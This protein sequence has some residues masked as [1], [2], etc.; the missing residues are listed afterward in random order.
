MIC[1]REL[2][3]VALSVVR[4]LWTRAARDRSSLNHKLFFFFFFFFFSFF[5]YL[6]FLFVF[7]NY[8]LYS[9]TLLIYTSQNYGIQLIK[10]TGFHYG[11]NTELSCSTNVP[12]DLLRFETYFK[13]LKCISNPFIMFSLFQRKLYMYHQGF[14]SSSLQLLFSFFI[15]L[16]KYRR[17]IYTM[18]FRLIEINKIK[19]RV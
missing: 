11:F 2:W 4:L 13:I 9:F 16:R 5:F 10:L 8:F 7:R 3:E 14:S 17:T 1:N 18:F 15:L 19:I 6:R 12:C